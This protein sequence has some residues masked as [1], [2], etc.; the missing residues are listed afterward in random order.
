ML[1]GE[2]RP[3]GHFRFVNFGH[4]PPL[5]FSAEY[6][7]SWRSMT[8]A[9]CSSS[10]WDWRFPK[11]IR[12]GTNTFP[13]PSRQRQFISSDVAEITLMSPGD[14][15]FL[16]TDGVYDG[17]DEQDRAQIEAVM[18]EHARQVGQRHL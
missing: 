11:T 4:P 13:W 5:V 15:L 17:S 14:M 2:V 9:W 18:R 6:E 7:S 10:R 8:P 1:Y 3:G 12:T 16:Y